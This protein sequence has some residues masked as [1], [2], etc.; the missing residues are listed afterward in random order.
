MGTNNRTK[1]AF[2][3]AAFF[4]FVAA[5]GLPLMLSLYASLRP[6]SLHESIGGA[7]FAL[8]VFGGPAA[9]CGFALANRITSASS[10]AS[11]FF[12]G[13]ILVVLTNLAAALCLAVLSRNSSLREF[14][15]F[16]VTM[17]FFFL[18]LDV[19]AFYGLPFIIGGIAAM[20]FRRA[21]I[22]ITNN[23]A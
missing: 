1:I 4:A 18:V 11:A 20:A 9:I 12:L 17:F 21:V 16:T 10:P 2:A 6:T 15:F 8:L 22:H 14:P 3:G 7:R 23:E 19:V 5:V 13:T